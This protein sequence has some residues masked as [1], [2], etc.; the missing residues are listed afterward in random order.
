ML[1]GDGAA[2]GT[3]IESESERLALQRV[4]LGVGEGRLGESTRGQ[5][6]GNESGG[7]LHFDNL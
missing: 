7:V 3:A 4:N 2:A 6:G 1:Q 5:N